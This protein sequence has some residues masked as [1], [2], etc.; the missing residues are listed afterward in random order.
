MSAIAV[1]PRVLGTLFYYSPTSEQA[2]SVIASLAELPELL[3]WPKPDLIESATRCMCQFDP[4][5]LSYQFSLLFEGQGHM[6][7]PPW[8][9]V[10]LDQEN[11]LLGDTSLD[12]RRFLAANRVALDTD[13]NEPD[14][15]FGLMLMALAYFMETENDDAVVELLGIHLLPWAGRYL[16]LV[17]EVDETSFY[18]ALAEVTVAFLREVALA[19]EVTVEPKQLYF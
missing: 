17:G 4:E 2:S 3:D 9:S 10:Y 19:Y 12:Y 5:Q 15:Q 16:E 6:A 1:L 11:L 7:A 14:D 13:Q 18:R 8:G